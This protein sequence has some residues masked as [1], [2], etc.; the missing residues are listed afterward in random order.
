MAVEHADDAAVGGHVG[1]QP[2]DVRARMNEAALAGAL[3]RGPAGVEAVGGGDGE[4]SDVAAVLAHQADGL[5][6][7][8]RDRAGVGDDD[9]AVRSRLAQPVGAIDDALAQFRRHLALDLLDRARRETEIDRAAG[10][11]AQ[12]VALGRGAVAV[13]LDVVERERHDR[14]KFVDERRLER[15]KPVLR[16]AD[17]RLRDRLVRAALGR[18]R[19]AGR[20]RDQNEARLLVAGVVQR[21]ETARDERVVQ[22]A[23]RQQPHAVDLMRQPKRGQ[24]DE[25]VHLGD[26][27][28]DVLAFRRE[29]PVEG[30]WDALALERVGHRLAREQAAA[31]DPR[32][33]VG[34]DRDIGRGGDDALRQRGLLARQLVEQR[35]EPELRRHGGLDRDRQ[36]VRHLD[37]RRLQAALAALRER[38]AVEERLEFVRRRGETLEPV[39]L[40]AGPDV[41]RARGRLSICVGVISPA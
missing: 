36:H 17:Q 6:R 12:P 20:R 40:V 30:R 34:R 19:D 11:V 33:E 8:G 13:F 1:K 29:L 4:Q 15:R 10:L 28:L 23:D 32:S 35:A 22:R 25:Q 26:A 9:L 41:H 7:L 16:H 5:D 21:I 24:Q 38:H 37:L 2:L 31:V 14:G 3:R 27:E 18:E 39:P